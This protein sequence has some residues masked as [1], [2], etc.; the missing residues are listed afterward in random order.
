MLMASQFVAHPFSNCLRSQVPLAHRGSFN[1]DGGATVYSVVA[2]IDMF[3]LKISSTSAFAAGDGV[4]GASPSMEVST[5][6]TATLS[7][8]LV[9][10]REGGLIEEAK[11][12]GERN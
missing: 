6:T 4:G 11:R 1:L 3:S 10:A 12:K 2:D 9:S 8:D 5:T 7:E